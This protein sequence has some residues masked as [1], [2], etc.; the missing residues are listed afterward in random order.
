LFRPRGS[1]TV[2]FADLRPDTPLNAPKGSGRILRTDPDEGAFLG[3]I[4]SPVHAPR[5]VALMALVETT[6]RELCRLGG[7]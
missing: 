5:E 2:I 3:I 1:E 4:P 7:S 6:L